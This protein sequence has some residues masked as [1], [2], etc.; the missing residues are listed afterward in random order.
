MLSQ[1]AGDAR[2]TAR[3]V[4]MYLR[5][6]GDAMDTLREGGDARNTTVEQR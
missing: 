4:R 5:D 1:H 6:G 3:C 2:V